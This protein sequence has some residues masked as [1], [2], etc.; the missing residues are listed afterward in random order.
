MC[1][2]ESSLFA[3]FRLVF[4]RVRWSPYPRDR[5]HFEADPWDKGTSGREQKRVES[6]QI[7]T[8]SCTHMHKY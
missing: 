5:V 4:V 3:R 1:V 6:V 8:T 2:Q 7:T